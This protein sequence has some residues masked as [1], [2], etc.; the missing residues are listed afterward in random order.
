MLVNN[1][2]NYGTCIVNWQYDE[3]ERIFPGNKVMRTTCIIKDLNK[4]IF[5]TG[6]TFLNPHDKLNKDKARKISLSR[7]LT[8][9]CTFIKEERT[10]FWNEYLRT[11][12]RVK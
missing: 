10:K 8:D 4:N 12:R 11:T 3:V 1:V 5:G 9:S 2:I 7:A 6:K